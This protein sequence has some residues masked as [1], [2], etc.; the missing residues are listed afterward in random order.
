MTR[1]LSAPQAAPLPRLLVLTNRTQADRPLPEVIGACVDGGARAVVLREK[2][3]PRAE[4]TALAVRLRPVLAA[5]GGL[6]LVAS[7]PTI[8]ADGVHLAANDPLTLGGTHGLIGRSCHGPDDLAAAAVEGCTHAT[9]SPTFAT[10]SKPGYG[11]ALGLDALADP[12]LPTFALGGI[13]RP[14]RAAACV[15]AGAHGVAVMGALMLADRP[16]RLA[17]EILAA[18]ADTESAPAGRTHG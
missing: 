3:L 4:R 17:A 2:D 13:D 11:P 15:A 12:P 18:L 16:D 14:E 10:A 5:T 8:P 7:D 9:L 6:L 1:F